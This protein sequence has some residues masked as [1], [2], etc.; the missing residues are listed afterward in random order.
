MA[1]FD[2]W[3]LKSAYGDNLGTFPKKHQALKIKSMYSKSYQKS[4]KVVKLSKPKK[5]KIG[6]ATRMA[7]MPKHE[8][9]W[10][11]ARGGYPLQFQPKKRK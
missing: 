2:K 4:M 10:I 9:N 6:F 8:K 3:K 1:T 11:T 7:V 5:S